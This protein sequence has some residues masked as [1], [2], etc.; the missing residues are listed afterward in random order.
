MKVVD[1]FGP[2][3]ATCKLSEIDNDTL[4]NFCLKANEPYN[5]KL[6]GNV[7]E[8][9]S[10]TEY[11]KNTE[12]LANISNH[13]ENYLKN[14]DAGLWETTVK[15][16]QLPNYLEL[17]D[18]WYNKQI[19]M[20]NTVLHDHRH[21]ADLVC[22]IFPKIYLD[23]DAEYFKTDQ[24][25]YQKGQLFFIYADSIKNDF[26]KSSIE[27]LPEEGDMF[28]FPSQLSHYTA[29]V[30]GESYR[31]SISCNFSFT[32]KAKNLL[33]KMNKNENRF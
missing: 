33:N 1:Y 2:K 4:Y 6:L 9:N 19:H 26:G 5:S 25:P 23:K 22:V 30:L 11:I 28:I 29:P 20:E 7:R 3:V 18:A 24:I 10:I 14:I 15:S 16:N 32:A 13:M 27:V 17:T 8:Q 12:V 31:Y 21:S